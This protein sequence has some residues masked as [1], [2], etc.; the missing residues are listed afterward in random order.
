MVD[1][2][3]GVVQIS[4]EQKQRADYHNLKIPVPY[5][6]GVQL[7]NTSSGTTQLLLAGYEIPDNAYAKAIEVSYANNTNWQPSDGDEFRV[8]AI[9]A[10]HSELTITQT[11]GTDTVNHNIINEGYYA[12]DGSK[13]FSKLYVGLD[14]PV[15]HDQYLNIANTSNDTDGTIIFLCIQTGWA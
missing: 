3:G 15:T 1:G 12:S 2:S 9:G 7:K 4:P 5:D 14:I 8:M 10:E 13:M 6:C 11:D